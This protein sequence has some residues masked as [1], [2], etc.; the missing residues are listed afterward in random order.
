MKSNF[1]T[2]ATYDD[3]AD[4]YY[5]KSLHPTCANFAELSER[6]FRRKLQPDSYKDKN[7]LEVGCG[8]SIV[9]ETLVTSGIPLNSLTLLDLS[10]RMLSYSEAWRQRGASLVVADAQDTKLLSHS[11]HLIISSLG[12]PY[13]G[14]RFWSEIER[15]LI[16]GGLCFFTTSSYEWA[17]RFRRGTD[18]HS[19]EFLRSD[20]ISVFVRSE[21]L[22]LQAQLSLIKDA[23]LIVE[24]SVPM[25]I[26]ELT[27]RPSPKLLI[28]DALDDSPIVHG[29]EIRKRA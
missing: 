29:F 20:G 1:S 8:R 17:Q 25:P 11:F 13:N 12:D 3:V 23:G 4:E 5:D 19:A 16:V 9:A 18:F 14:A 6:F 26:S 21:I 24:N 10:P 27:G 2:L 7:V 28:K 15:L 22:P